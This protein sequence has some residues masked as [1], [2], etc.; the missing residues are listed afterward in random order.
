MES[1]VTKAAS[2]VLAELE[3]ALRKHGP[4]QSA[5]EGYAVILEEVEELWEEVRTQ[6]PSR[7]RM[8]AEASQIGAL[9]LRFMLD[10]CREPE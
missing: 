4:M 5:H 6:N 10:V 1:T 9:A 7:E 3:K 2:I 8:L